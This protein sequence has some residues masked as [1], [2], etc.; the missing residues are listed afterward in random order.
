MSPKLYVVVAST[1]PGRLGL[2]VGRWFLQVAEAFGGFAIE[3]VDLA[4]WNLPFMDEPHH[5]R[6]RQYTQDHT[7]RWSAHI[8]RADAFV[9][10]MPEYNH[11][12]T[13][14]LK[15]AIDYL[16]AEWAYKPVGFVSYGGIA[17]GTRAVQLLKPVLVA[18]KMTPIVEAVNIPF[19]G[20]HIKDGRFEG[21]ESMLHA[22][23]TLL[24]ELQRS[25]ELLSPLR[26]S[27]RER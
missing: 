16:V 27:A 23:Q 3:W 18:L 8:D 7:Q 20:Q 1:R 14:P 6:L 15:N 26:T 21:T 13:A 5:P 25:E 11:G 17:A 10:V 2:P 12:F 22:A 19:V 24:S 4:E 9:L